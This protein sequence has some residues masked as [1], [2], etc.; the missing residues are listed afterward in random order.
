MK[1]IKI[2]LLFLLFHLFA[3]AN[4][5]AIIRQAT[6]M[7]DPEAGRIMQQKE[8]SVLV[9]GIV[10]LALGIYPF[11]KGII[12]YQTAMNIIAPFAGVLIGLVGGVFVLVGLLVIGRYLV[13]RYW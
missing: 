3:P 1:S 5:Y 6:E 13:Q 9:L 4:S 11:V 7:P 2:V 8:K 12:M 10:F